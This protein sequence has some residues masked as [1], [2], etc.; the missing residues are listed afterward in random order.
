MS[1]DLF[2]TELLT[3]IAQVKFRPNAQTFG[4]VSKVAG[5]FEDKFE[6]WSAPKTEQI[7]LYSPKKSEAL[8]LGY[9][10]VSYI[11]E[12]S[13]NTA[14]AL[15]YTIEAYKEFEKLNIK[16][17]RWVG[18]RTT[19]IFKSDINFQD[20]SDLIYKKFYSQEAVLKKI[21]TD[22]IRDVVF[23]LDSIKD[24]YKNHIQIG[25]VKGTELARWYTFKFEAPEVKYK[26]DDTLL[27]VDCDV[28]TDK[29]DTSSKAISDTINNLKILNE[30]MVE[31]Y[32]E[33]LNN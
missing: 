29:C 20:L 33:Y 11:T 27:F 3:L 23:I 14:K 15:K 22:K 32:Q 30:A 21:S 6:E 2:H 31:Q 4:G 12:K 1:S 17:V 7:N 10:A 28:H 19:N 13:D 24:G 18:Y 5:M 9:N 25:P 16:E 26:E 8:E